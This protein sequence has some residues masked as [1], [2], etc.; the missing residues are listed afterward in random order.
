MKKR[1]TSPQPLQKT[2]MEKVAEKLDIPKELA[3]QL[4][5]LI[6]TGHR[7]LYIENYRG[8]LEYTDT[9][10]RIA[11]SSKNVKVCGNALGIKSIASEE[12]T[13]EGN[14]QSVQFE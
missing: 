14:I 3:L 7:E 8:I 1:T 4:P 10:I 5:R 11:T 9:L 2:A 12:I 13:L 6:L